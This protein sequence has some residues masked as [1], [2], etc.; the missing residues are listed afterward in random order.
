MP[1][2]L[3]FSLCLV[4]NCSKGNLST[5][6]IFCFA[7]RVVNVLPVQLTAESAWKE[8]LVGKQRSFLVANLH[9]HSLHNLSCISLFPPLKGFSRERQMWI[10]L[11]IRIVETQ[12]SILFLFELCLC[13]SLMNT[14]CI[15]W[16]Y[17]KF[18][19]C[20]E[21][22][23]Q[24]NQIIRCFV[25]VLHCLVQSTLND[26]MAALSSKLYRLLA[27]CKLTL[28][29]CPEIYYK[30]GNDFRTVLRGCIFSLSLVL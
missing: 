21:Q 22:F 14:V 23:L 28:I 8:K 26:N 15:H 12:C 16:W 1:Q 24:R 11:E 30:E 20:E 3:I 6:P 17:A 5:L 25:T 2:N 4:P 19:I 9:P 29:G 13:E 18:R 10:C 7:Y 27:S